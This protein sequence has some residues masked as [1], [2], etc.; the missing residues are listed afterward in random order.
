MRLDSQR[1]PENEILYRS[2]VL[3]DFVPEAKRPEIRGFKQQACYIMEHIKIRIN[4][5]KIENEDIIFE[6]IHLLPGYIDID[7]DIDFTHI[8]LYVGDEEKHKNQIVEQGENRSLYK[9]ENFSRIRSFRQYLLE[10]ALKEQYKY[11]IKVIESNDQTINEIINSMPN[12]DKEGAIK[13][14]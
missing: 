6:G 11:N 2:A 7:S 5:A 4:Q 14:D 9:L 3:T 13:H 1:T 8:I 10:K 12:L